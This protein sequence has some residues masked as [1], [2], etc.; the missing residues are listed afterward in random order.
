MCRF[1]VNW[2]S[3]GTEISTCFNTYWE[4]F[5]RYN[6]LRLVTRRCELID[7]EKGILRK[8]YMKKLADNIHF[9]REEEIMND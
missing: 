4:A 3:N 1:K 2:I 6:E 7:E 5:R 8:T 9:R